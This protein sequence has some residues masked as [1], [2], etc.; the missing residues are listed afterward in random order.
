M[1]CP[2]CAGLE[3][4]FNRRFARLELWMYHRKGPAKTTRL[5]I[6]AV[7]SLPVEG[8]TLLDIG[9]GIGAIQH[10]LLKAGMNRAIHVDA[11]TAYIQS[12]R[13]EARRQGLLER[14]EY[15]HGDFV[16]LAPT[17]PEADVVT[18]DRVICC[19]PD[20]PGLVSAS[21]SKARRLYGLVFPRDVWYVKVG[22]PLLN[23]GCWI[24]RNP[25][26]FYVHPSREVDALITGEGFSR[27]FFRKTFTWQVVVY[28][29]M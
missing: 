21:L 29:R 26:R 9:G 25:Y 15:H 14:I 23:F 8:A 13:E 5:L 12:A 3:R 7:K 11:S 18:L 20:M 17:L 19:Y 1:S 28:R 16:E 22:R 24:T 6:E 4:L 2:Q 10:H 27:V